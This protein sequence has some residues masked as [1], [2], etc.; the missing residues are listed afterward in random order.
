MFGIK[1]KLDKHDFPAHA[2]SH[3]DILTWNQI[4]ILILKKK[5]AQTVADVCACRWQ[6]NKR[7]PRQ[8]RQSG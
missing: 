3:Q 4:I 6:E 2:S 8:L 5:P 7:V 1:F